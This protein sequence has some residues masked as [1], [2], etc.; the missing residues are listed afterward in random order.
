MVLKNK[1]PLVILSVIAI[2][3]VVLF[4]ALFSPVYRETFIKIPEG[5]TSRQ[6]ARI[7]KKEKIIRSE[8]IFLA[9][10]W[11]TRTEKKLKPGTYKFHNRLPDFIILKNIVRG[12]TYKIKITIPEGFTAKEIAE[13][14]GKKGICSSRLFLEIVENK[15]MEGYLFPETYFFEPDS[16]EKNV[17]QALNKQFKKIFTDDFIEKARELNLTK[18]EIIILAS[19]IE[20]EAKREEERPLISAVFHNRLRKRWNLESCATVLYALGRHKEF[21]VYKDLEI[22]SPFNTYIHSGL[23]PAPIANPGLASIKAALY[24]AVTDDMFF[25]VAG[26]GTHKFS[27]YAKDHNSKKKQRKHGINRR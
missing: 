12:N 2:T 27:K 16:K 5:S 10:A 19:I 7:L 25:I 4:V 26:S 1:F 13:L 24:P 15:K 22:D 17:V 8:N 18:E 23:P 9:I 11:L 21:L 20:K 3:A 14:L 6:V